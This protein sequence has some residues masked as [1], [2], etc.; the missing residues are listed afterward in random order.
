MECYTKKK[1][2]C[3]T[4]P[5]GRNPK[6]DTYIVSF[7]LQATSLISSQQKKILYNLSPL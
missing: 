5:Q 1:N 3:F 4:P 6:L 7:R 2:R